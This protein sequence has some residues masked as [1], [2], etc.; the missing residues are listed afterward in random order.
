MDCKIHPSTYVRDDR[1]WT[2]ATDAPV[3]VCGKS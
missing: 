2:E 1:V 3:L